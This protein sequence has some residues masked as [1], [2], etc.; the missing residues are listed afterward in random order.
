MHRE[1]MR[2][3]PN[4]VRTCAINRLVDGS[5]TFARHEKYLKLLGNE[6]VIVLVPRGLSKVLNDRR[7]E[8]V[9]Y[10][11]YVFTMVHNTLYEN[12]L[13]VDN[14]IG[15]NCFVHP[16]AVMDVEGMHVTKSPEGRR[17]QLKH[18]GNVVL[19][20]DVLVLALA[21]LQRAVFGS[22]LVK[23]GA[24]IDSHVNIGHNSVIGE[25]T[26]LALGSIVGGSVTVGNN[27]MIGLGAV[28]R[29]GITI[30]DNVIVGMGSNVVSDI[31][32]PGIY[33][34]SPA[35]FSKPY[36]KDWNF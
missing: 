11:D 34:G 35:K 21:T 22:T 33:M 29:N 16:T 14:V 32:E 20:D 4:Y 13:P 15:N 8:F 27:C 30:C 1:I 28:L 7:C 10:V 31:S 17:I 2:K 24:K 26:V 12:V 36:D 23:R 18:V 5:I 25:N 19:E 9:D 6:D 3:Y